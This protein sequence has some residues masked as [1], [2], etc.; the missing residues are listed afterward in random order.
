MPRSA[1]GNFSDSDATGKTGLFMAAL[2][3]NLIDATSTERYRL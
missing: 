2:P 3:L 1:F